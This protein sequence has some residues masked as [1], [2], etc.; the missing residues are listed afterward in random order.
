MSHTITGRTWVIGDSIDTDALYPG[1]A[2][3]LPVP[4]AATHVLYDLRPGWAAQVRP[5]DILVAGRNFGIGSSRQVAALLR[6]LG[7][8][9]LVAEDFNSLFHRNAINHGLPAVTVPGVSGMVTE[10]DVITLDLEA[11]LLR[12]GDT[13]AAFS[14]VPPM[15]LEILDAGGLL[16]R[17]VAAGYLADPSGKDRP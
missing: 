4:E 11:G 12:N 10:G 9:A 17:L 2:M 13:E 6:Y 15:M 16:P 14:P 1:F 3:R 7:I 8:S 5:G